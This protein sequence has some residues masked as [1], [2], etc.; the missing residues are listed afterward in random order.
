M[1]FFF[2]R[3][4]LKTNFS[5]YWLL[6][7]IAII[8]FGLRFDTGGDWWNY[9]ND[10]HKIAEQNY[11]ILFGDDPQNIIE[12]S[13]ITLFW[14]LSSISIEYGYYIYHMIAMLIGFLSLYFLAKEQPYFWLTITISVHLFLIILI[15]GYTRQGIAISLMTIGIYF[16]AKYKIKHFILLLITAVTFHASAIIM[17]VLALP[18]LISTNSRNKTFLIGFAFILL[19][20]GADFIQGYIDKK[21]QH[22]II[23]SMY[24]VG[25]VPRLLITALAGFFFFLYKEKWKS[26]F[27]DYDLWRFFAILSFLPLPLLLIIPSTTVDR[28]AFYLLPL[29]LVVWPRVIY[30]SEP[31]ERKLLTFGVVSGYAITLYVWLNYAHNV[32]MWLPFQ[33]LLF[34]E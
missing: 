8:I 33:H 34:T 12:F 7:S 2:Q 20:I 9:N 30:L 23:E 5:D 31:L 29:Q 25:T 3:K 4:I 32:N 24:S 17:V 27:A 14:I 22:Y 16:L 1:L 6:A 26:V 19:I 21:S 11:F 18:F 10:F 15:M 13:H 28:I